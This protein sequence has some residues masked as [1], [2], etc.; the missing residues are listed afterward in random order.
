[1]KIKLI[2]VR[3][4]DAPATAIPQHPDKVFAEFAEADNP[5]TPSDL[6]GMSGSP[7]FGMR[8]VEGT[9]KYWLVG[10]QSGWFERSRKL[11]IY[12]IAGLLHELNSIVEAVKARLETATAQEQSRA[13]R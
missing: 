11:T 5:I 2:P 13:D 1:L 6:A 12:P 10:I 9:L 7:V 4:C 3:V 8:R